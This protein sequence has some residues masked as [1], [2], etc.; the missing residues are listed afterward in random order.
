MKKSPNVTIMINAARAAAKSLL[1]DFGEV[2]KLQ[3]SEKGPADFV[4]NADTK[5]EKIIVEQL[6]ASRPEYGILAEEGNNFESKSEFRYVIDPLDGTN[7]FLHGFP[8]WAI[9]IG[10]EKNGEIV[11]GVVMA[12]VFD[13]IYWAEKGQGAYLNDRRIRVSGRK[14]FRD[15]FVG[16]GSASSY[17]RPTELPFTIRHVLNRLGESV[18]SVR[19]MNAAALDLAFVACGRFDAMVDTGLKKW[20][21]CAGI[22]LV[23]EAGGNVTGILE[24]AKD[25]YE[26]GNILATN[27]HL[28]DKLIRVLSPTEKT[29]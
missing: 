6:K 2:E 27:Y 7:N 3:I 17:R 29:E 8:Y 22:A 26:S 4:S 9:S 16:C 1:R 10:L 25:Y 23:R 5:A 28:H 24:D 20:D 13:E 14:H 11:A 18:A 15:A 21:S 12:P 19:C